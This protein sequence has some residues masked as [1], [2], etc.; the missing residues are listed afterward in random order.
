MA[1]SI[2]NVPK[3]TLFC[4]TQAKDWL[5]SIPSLQIVAVNNTVK[6]VGYKHHG[7]EKTARGPYE[8]FSTEKAQIAKRA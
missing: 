4:Q 5:K 6:A 7:K 8:K 2:L 3:M 1:L